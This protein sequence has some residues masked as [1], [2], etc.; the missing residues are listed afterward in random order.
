MTRTPKKMGLRPHSINTKTKSF[1][2]STNDIL[3]QQNKHKMR[4]FVFAFIE[5][6][7][8]SSF[9]NDVL[10]SFSF[11]VFIFLVIE[12]NYSTGN[13]NRPYN[14]KKN[15]KGKTSKNRFLQKGQEKLNLPLTSIDIF[16][17]TKSTM[18]GIFN[19]SSSL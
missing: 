18:I 2:F 13:Q 14:R 7:R 3:D 16:Y 1:W 8:N 10:E 9:Y 12:V 19:L 5:W 6:G 15:T 17:C 4:D 11:G